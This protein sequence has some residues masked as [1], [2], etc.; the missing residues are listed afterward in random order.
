M[1]S[2]SAVRPSERI[3][4]WDLPLRLFHWLLVVAIALAFLSSEEGSALGRWHVL[5]GWVAGLLVVFRIVWGFVGGEHSRF[6]DFVRPSH[7]RGHV[8]ALLRGRAEPSLGHNA[9]G[10]VSVLL[11]LA[12]VAATVAT[13]VLLVEDLHELL[14]WTLLA[15]VAVHV[16]AVVA[17]SV[18]TRENLVAAMISGTKPAHRHAGA[19]DA[20]RPGLIGIILAAAILGGAVYAVQVYD[21]LAFTLRS[22]DDYEHGAGAMR[23]GGAGREGEDG[24]HDR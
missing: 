4:V 21:P 10:A 5:S 20:R 17:M 18:M 7:L 22:A 15:L 6:A 1:A 19:G 24:D 2:V 16:A 14:A 3:R 23:G 9:L 8:S 12:L 11:L 13:G